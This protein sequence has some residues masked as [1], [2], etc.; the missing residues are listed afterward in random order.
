MSPPFAT[1]RARALGFGMKKARKSRDLGVR[2]LARLTHLSPQEISNWERGKRVPRVEEVATILGALR[3]EPDERARLVDLA[4]TANE[5]NWLEQY[6][7]PKLATFVE[8]EQTAE[9][10]FEW[11]PALVPGL[12]QTPAY[13][14]AL[15]AGT[16]RRKPDIE[17]RIMVRLSRREVL[18]AQNPLR[19]QALL[20]EAALRQGIGDR[21]VM[22]GQLRHLIVMTQARNVSLRVLPSGGGYHPGLY[23]PFV[24]FG[25][26]DLPPIVHLEH[27]RGSG[28]LY[29]DQHV[30]DYRA[31]TESLLA[32]ALGEADSARLIQGVLAE[33]EA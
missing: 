1:P 20:G 13:I 15:F 17:N 27:Y 6:A 7:P 18:T 10:M 5:P 14:R 3:V 12:L 32:L 22:A 24:I 2:E 26:H 31:A 11:V 9:T 25:F 29:D 8:Y 4:R 21:A 33:T 30:A 19:Y 28:Y 23:G 16:S